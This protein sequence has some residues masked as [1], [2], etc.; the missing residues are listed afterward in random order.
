[1][2]SI[3]LGARMSSKQ[4][5]FVF[6]YEDPNMQTLLYSNTS[7]NRKI[8]V[9]EDEVEKQPL[10]LDSVKAAGPDNIILSTRVLKTT[11]ETAQYLTK[12]FQQSIDNG[13]LPYKQK[14]G[15]VRAVFN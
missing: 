10:S 4:H 12:I 3:A 11:N 6:T 7:I 13:F 2:E 5:D 9:T 1:M 15:N 14:R 8:I